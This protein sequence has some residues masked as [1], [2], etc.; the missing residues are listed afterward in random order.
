MGTMAGHNLVENSVDCV[1]FSRDGCIEWDDMF[2][3]K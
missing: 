1:L 2:S 3:E